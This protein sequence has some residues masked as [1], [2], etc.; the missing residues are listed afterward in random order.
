M[1]ES[2]FTLEMARKFHRRMASLVDM[3]Q[4]GIWAA[5]QHSLVGYSTDYAFGQD[6]GRQT[7][8]LKTR[9]RSTYV[10]LQWNTILG[11]RP[12]DRLMVDEA[13]QRAI[14]DLS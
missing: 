13:T 4:A 11:D 8:V 6:R 1:E 7:L 14:T 2:D 10:R 12:A 3:V 9:S 5:G